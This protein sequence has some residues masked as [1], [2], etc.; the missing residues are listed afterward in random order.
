MSNPTRLTS[1]EQ[2]VETLL[3]RL[4]PLQTGPARDRLMFQ[5]GRASAGSVRRW[6]GISGVLTVLLFCSLT[7]GLWHPTIQSDQTHA[8]TPL[9]TDSVHPMAYTAQD[10][11][12]LEEGAYIQVRSRVLAEGLDGLPDSKDRPAVATD[13]MSPRD[14]LKRLINM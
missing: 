1:Q 3:G 8:P 13:Y 10:I 5:A 2:Q 7:V 4:S 9:T 11:Q 14:T 12:P 6:Q